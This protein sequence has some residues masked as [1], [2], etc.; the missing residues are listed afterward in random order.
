MNSLFELYSTHQGKV[1]DKWGIYLPT[2]DRIFLPYRNKPV[3][4]LEVG[5]QN[6]GSLEIWSKYFTQAQK[7]IG[8]DINPACAA[9]K[10]ADP[11]VAI[12][13][14]DAN[15]DLAERQISIHALHFDIVIDDGSHRSSDIIKTFA[16][17]FPKVVD[18]GV[19]VAEDLHCS[20]WQEFEGGLHDPYSSMSFFKL[21]ADVVNHEH[22]GA[23]QKRDELTKGIAKRYGV[24]LHEELLSC[25]HSV[26]FV[27]S[28]CVIRKQRCSDNQ[29]G[30]RIVTGQLALVWSDAHKVAKENSVPLNQSSNY[31]TTL[32]RPPGELVKDY[33]Y[34]IAERD[35]Q[36]V[37][38]NQ[39][40]TERDGMI[41]RLSQA[42]SER[43]GQIVSLSQTISA[44]RN[45]TSWRVTAPLRY[46]RHQVKRVQYFLSVMPQL[47]LRAGGINATAT[48]IF[49]ILRREGI[50]GIKSRWRINHSNADSRN[51]YQEWIRRY[52]TLDDA[53]RHRIRVHVKQMQSPPLI[54]VVM[55]TYNS[56]PKWLTV[57]IESVR[58][59]LYPHWEL[60]IADD[61]STDTR[62]RPI[63]EGFAKRDTRIKVTFRAKNSHISEASN[64]AL[65]MASGEWIA[66][67]DH[68][69]LISETALYCVAQQI[70]SQPNVRLI[71]S[72][73]DKID[74]A[75][76][77]HSPYFKCDW[78][79]DLF[80][81]H[82]MFSHLGVYQ[83]E[84]V[85]SV[86]GF[87]VG[88]EGAQDYDLA[89]R[90]IECIDA[91]QIAHIPKVLYHWRVHSR[92][93]AGGAE[94]KPYAMLAGERALSEHF[95][96]EGIPGQV[97]L[98]D[99]GYRVRYQLPVDQPLVTLLMP[100][101]DQKKITE[102]AVQSILEKT[103]YQNYEILIIDNGSI[104]TETLDWFQW[105]QS[106]D[107]RVK[108]IRY[109][110]P[111]NYSAI[112]NYGVTLANGAIIGLINN[113]IEVIEPE[114]LSEMVSHSLRAEIGCVG[115]KLYYSSGSLQHCGVVLGIGGVAGHSH[116]HFS[117]NSYG[118]FSRMQLIS[119][120]SAVTGAC[121]LV[122]KK[123][124]ESVGGL[125]EDNLKVA[126]NDVD[127]CL[128]VRENGYRNLW[129]PYAELYHH[130][131]IS[132]GAEDTPEKM[133]RFQA[134]VLFMKSKWG[135]KLMQDPCYSPNL[136][137]DH[138]DFSLAWPPR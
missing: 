45:S 94:A 106:Q 108:V 118:Y 37:S 74:E 15:T 49:R 27:N 119:N 9:L 19:F 7:L 4:L 54:S 35:G 115:A 111:F 31:W 56:D 120:F 104:E 90:C 52:D 29:L 12:V 110:H 130:E 124:F 38:L 53:G 3:L 131:S 1:S 137:L 6:G 81:S 127:F 46:A 43:D 69:D 83:L 40:V 84:L 23:H 21:L 20:Y 103:T 67:L 68:D 51:D 77:R 87:R 128:K 18:G 66:L 64:T 121:L 79:P 17:Y 102:L 136:T 99:F 72:D 65:D 89:L 114:W 24:T 41:V 135:S 80:Y 82:N 100:T 85:R 26:E 50:Q 11:R 58:S 48:K 132:R 76:L 42:V 47:I 86:G 22:W 61:A 93:T 125:D 78:N 8:C 25:I 109:D 34:T 63:L 96:R 75:G 32:V 126:F 70:I 2:Y 59:Q 138:E 123:I 122:K 91:G 112:N 95:Q 55:P 14:G 44:L 97:T 62:I 39:A 92:S 71:Y 134:E 30:E 133:I 16:R 113:D 107:S 60:C 10:Y 98:T 13:V 105:I 5:V 57:A 33:E 116:K 101:R 88:F 73:E 117:K 129:T 36:I 28:I